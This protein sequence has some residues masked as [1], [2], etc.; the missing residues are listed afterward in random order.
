M[1]ERR[2]KM[3]ERS[4]NERDC[5]IIIRNYIKDHKKNNTKIRS[6]RQMYNNIKVLEADGILEFPISLQTFYRYAEKMNLQEISPG[7][8]QFDFIVDRP[9]S[10]NTYL[11]RKDFNNFVCYKLKDITYGSLIVNYLNDYYRNYRKSFHCVL[12]SDMIICFFTSPDN[13]DIEN[14]EKNGSPEFLSKNEII[15]KI[16]RCLK[17][18]TITKTK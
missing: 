13:D 14:A 8:Q 2:K 7:S 11:I 6:L 18:Y 4:K 3:S 10:L 1:K 5:A 15:K 9:A 12:L 16:R 17:K